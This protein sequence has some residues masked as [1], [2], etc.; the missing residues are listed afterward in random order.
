MMEE[1]E[2]FRDHPYSWRD[3]LHWYLQIPRREYRG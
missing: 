1:R 3:H 2:S